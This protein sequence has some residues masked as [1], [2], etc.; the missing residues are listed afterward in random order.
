VQGCLV[1]TAVCE[2]RRFVVVH[3]TGIK[4]IGVRCENYGPEKG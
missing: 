1:D 4:R 2:D 3:K